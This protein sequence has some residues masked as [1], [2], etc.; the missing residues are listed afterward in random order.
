MNL[1]ALDLACVRGF[2]SMDN[3]SNLAAACPWVNVCSEKN[4]GNGFEE[5]L[6]VFILGANS[7][8]S[9]TFK[10]HQAKDVLGTG[11][12]DVA[13]KTY[14]FADPATNQRLVLIN[15]RS[16]E[17]DTQNGYKFIRLRIEV[18]AGTTTNISA[19][20]F[21]FEQST[22]SAITHNISEVVGLIK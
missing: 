9:I 2:L 22:N 14:T 10:L 8:P 17:L 1:S 16:S 3:Y 5:W 11:V 4:T 15:C 7:S 20:L 6:G 19:L 21:G 13:G 12:K 18:T